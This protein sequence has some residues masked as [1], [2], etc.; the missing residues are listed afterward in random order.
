MTYIDIL[1]NQLFEPKNPS[2][3]ASKSKCLVQQQDPSS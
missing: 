2:F 3:L 1:L